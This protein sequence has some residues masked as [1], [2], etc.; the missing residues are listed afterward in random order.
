MSLERMDQKQMLMRLAN[1]TFGASVLLWVIGTTRKQREKVL[2]MA[3]YA[4]EIQF[5]WTRMVA[6]RKLTWG[7]FCFIDC[8][9]LSRRI[10]LC[11]IVGRVKDIFKTPEGRQISPFQVE[12]V[13]LS[14]PQ[15][16]IADAVVAGVSVL[17]ALKSK[18]ELKGEI[19][20][21]WIV[22]SDEGKKLG[23][24]TVIKELEVWYQPRLGNHKW[25]HGGIEIVDKV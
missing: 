8:A 18:D 13:L 20:R 7:F 12:D 10:S 16:L 4:P 5:E 24:D 23:A 22:L 21:G 11:S 15:G 1:C 9:N 2:S 3:G 19:P 17:P 14:E 6:F 25:L